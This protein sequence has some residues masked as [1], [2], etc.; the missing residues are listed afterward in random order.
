MNNVL[1]LKRIFAN[2]VYW[3]SV[4][5]AIFLLFCSIVGEDS[6]TGKEYMFI[7]LFYDDTV[8]ELLEFGRI[9]ISQIVL[10]QDTSYLWMFCPIIVG[11]PCILTG[12][13]ERF[14]M[15]RTSK[16]K[17]L[18]SKYLSN[19]LASGMILFISYLVF[20]L[21]GMVLTQENLWNIYLVKKL[22][23]VFFWGIYCAIPSIILSELVENK[24]LIL[25]IPFVI[26]YFMCMFLG[27]IFS[28]EI[29]SYLSPWGYQSLLLSDSQK[30]VGRFM[31]LLSL[32]VACAIMKKIVLE[33]RCDCGQR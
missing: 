7:Q 1:F 9:S 22:L 8:R 20:A 10:G 16:N 5:A 32:I 11:I 30:M 3:I 17:Y 19:L 24:Y 14:V 21:L 28:Y 33:R 15:F 29:Q 12:R 31:I 25:C 18:F 4:L 27:S 26:N 13:T 2:K 23:S 6:A